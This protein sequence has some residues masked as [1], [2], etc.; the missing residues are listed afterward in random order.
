MIFSLLVGP[1]ATIDDVRTILVYIGVCWLVGLAVIRGMI[2]DLEER[3][4]G[5]K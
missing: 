4:R 3:L 5:P 2:A 1:P